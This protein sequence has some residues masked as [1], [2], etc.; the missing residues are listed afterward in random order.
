MADQ[1]LNV[2]EPIAGDSDGDAG[3]DDARA[4]GRYIPARDTM[5]Q[6]GVDVCDWD[7]LG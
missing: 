4:L 7:E 1:T 5:C 6:S 2:D 3:G